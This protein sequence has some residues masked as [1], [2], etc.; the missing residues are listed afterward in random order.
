MLASMNSSRG[1]VLVAVLL[2]VQVGLFLLSMDAGAYA[3]ISVFCTGP[4]TSSLGLLFGLLHLLFFGLLLVGAVSLW[5]TG[6]RL[7]YV[8]LLAVG[9]LMLPIQ[10]TLVAN[11]QLSCDGP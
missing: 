11:D 2:L 4:A 3:K 9:L 6:L 10:A 1:G 7:F 5:V 8:G